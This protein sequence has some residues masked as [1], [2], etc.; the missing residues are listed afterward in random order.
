MT[1]SQRNV[2]RFMRLGYAL[3]NEG[4]DM[5]DKDVTLCRPDKPTVRVRPRDFRRLIDL[6]R[7]G[8]RGDEDCG[9]WVVMP[10]RR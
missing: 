7:L 1:T 2:L 3:H 5:G 4:G 6:G 9:R 10:R 8:W